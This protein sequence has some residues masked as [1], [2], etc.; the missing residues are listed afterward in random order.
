M[1]IRSVTLK[2]NAAELCE[3]YLFQI[4]AIEQLGELEF[5]SPVTFFVGE[6][7][8]GKS[9]TVSGQVWDSSRNQPQPAKTVH[10]AGAAVS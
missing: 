2:E 4:P 9:E 3:D 1:Y 8:S 10:R 5:T 7:G 6:N